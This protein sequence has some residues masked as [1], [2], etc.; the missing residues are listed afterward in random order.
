MTQRPQSS[1]QILIFQVFI[2]QELK[3]GSYQSITD[4]PDS[5]SDSEL[6]SMRSTEKGGGAVKKNDDP[7]QIAMNCILLYFSNFYCSQEFPV[8]RSQKRHNNFC[9]PEF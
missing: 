5:V 9:P 6:T 2:R 4:R 3:Y 1:S 7:C 8:N